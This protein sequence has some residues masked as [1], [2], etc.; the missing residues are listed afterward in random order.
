MDVKS[1]VHRSR[2]MVGRLGVGWG[3]VGVGWGSAPVATTPSLPATRG[4]I[5]S[6]SE[7]TP[8]SHNTTQKTEAEIDNTTDTPTESLCVNEQCCIVEPLST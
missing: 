3:S 7:R 1:Y 6:L 4:V 8:A 5:S 2:R